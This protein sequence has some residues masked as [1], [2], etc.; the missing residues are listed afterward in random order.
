MYKFNPSRTGYNPNASAPVENVRKAW[1]F[2]TDGKIVT[3]PA[4]VG[5]SVYAASRDGFLYSL[6][7]SDG[8]VQWTFDAGND[9][10]ASPTVLDGSVFTATESGKFYAVDASDGTEKWASEGIGSPNRPMTAHDGR[11]YVLT[12][13][14]HVINA[15]DG[16]VETSFGSQSDVAV[17]DDG[18]YYRRDDGD[19]IKIDLDTFEQEWRFDIFD[20]TGYL[21][22]PIPDERTVYSPGNNVRAIDDSNGTQRWES[23]VYTFRSL[24]VTNDT[25]YAPRSDNVFEL[26]LITGSENNLFETNKYIDVYSPVLTDEAIIYYSN[27][28][29]S[30][31]IRAA[32]PSDGS[33]LWSYEF[34]SKINQAPA[35]S[36]GVFVGTEE[37]RIIALEGSLDLSSSVD[38]GSPG[39]ETTIDLSLEN[40]GISIINGPAID[41]EDVPDGWTI[42]NHTDDTGRFRSSELQWLWLQ[43]NSGNKVEPSITFSIP[44]D[45]EPRDYDFTVDI[46]DSGG[47]ELSEQVTVPVSRYQSIPEALAGSDDQFTLDELQTAI[48]H[49]ARDEPVPDTGGETIDLETIQRLIRIWATDGT[50]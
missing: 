47:T 44:E 46:T 2:Q 34:D 41:V 11:V 32:D 24:V 43:L 33:P 35:V 18:I 17:S 49:W 12:E 40:R 22:S 48:G 39:N 8:S 4:K 9:L 50:V 21:E 15:E 45:A 23:N 13:K 30:G 31:W 7:K 25:M 38:R 16:E 19:V 3:S 36:D 42:S 1:E 29:R 37:G 6:A 26:D 27:K 5:N 28:D 20:E 14:L 10:V